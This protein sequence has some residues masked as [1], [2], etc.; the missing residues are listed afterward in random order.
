MTTNLATNRALRITARILQILVAAAFLL[1]AVKALDINAFATEIR[2]YGIFPDLSLFGAWFFVIVEVMLAMS[3]LVNAFPR[4]TALAMLV[5]LALFVAVTAYALAIGLQGSC[6]CFGNLVHRTPQQVIVEDVLMMCAMLFVLLVH[7][8]QHIT[9]AVWKMVLILLSGAAAAGLAIAAPHL[10]LDSYVTDLRVGKQFSSW[11]VEGLTRDL[12]SGTHFVFLFTS[13]SKT[14][15]TDVAMMNAVAQSE[16]IP[17]TIGLLTEGTAKVTEVMFQ[18]GTAFPVG[19]LE[20]KFARYLYRT[21]PRAFILR[22]GE[23]REVWSRIP[24]PAEAQQAMRAVNNR[25]ATP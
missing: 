18:Y 4:T 3:L 19:A 6:G 20:P 2:G 10:P 17:S 5:L 21:L 15:E 22:D 1:A 11:P 23:V 24:T 7:V 14:I 25:P 8:K 13:T 12:H 9:T 16:D